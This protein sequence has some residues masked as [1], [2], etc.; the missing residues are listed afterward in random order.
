MIPTA[1]APTTIGSDPG[2]NA[3]RWEDLVRVPSLGGESG[4][5]WQELMVLAAAD[6]RVVVETKTDFVVLDVEWAVPSP[7]EAVAVL[8]AGMRRSEAS[9]TLR[10][11]ATSPGLDGSVASRRAVRWTGKILDGIYTHGLAIAEV[12]HAGAGGV[13]LVL[14]VGARTVVVEI[15]ADERIASASRDRDGSWHPG[16]ELVASDAAVATVVRALLERARA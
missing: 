8:P 4:G 11:L 14:D 5:L 7:G 9:A 13:V 3:R 15:D 12:G 10:G 16:I 6:D 2:Y 1:T